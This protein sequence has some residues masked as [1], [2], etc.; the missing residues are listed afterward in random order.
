M[1]V[2][3]TCIAHCTGDSSQCN[4]KEIKEKEKENASRL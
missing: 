2:L 3:T 4:Q 1:S